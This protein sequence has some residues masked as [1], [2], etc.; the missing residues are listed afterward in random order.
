MMSMIDCLYDI[1]VSWAGP[2]RPPPDGTCGRC[3]GRW[4]GEG[5]DGGGV[6]KTG[7]RTARARRARR[8]RPFSLHLAFSGL[9]RISCKAA[10]LQILPFSGLNRSRRRALLF[11]SCHQ[12]FE[13]NQLKG[14]PSSDP[15]FQWLE[16]NQTK[17]SSLQTLYAVD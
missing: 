8:E 9:N 7:E 10:P 13:S 6:A 11:R 5:E 1:Q 15:S 16:S 2:S 17:G 3:G 14:R 12:W 4:L